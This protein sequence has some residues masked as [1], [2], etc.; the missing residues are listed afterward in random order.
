LFKPWLDEYDG[1]NVLFQSIHLH[2]KGF[3]PNTGFEE[4]NQEKYQPGGIFNYPIM[5]GAATSQ[6]W[7]KIISD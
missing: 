7:R 2:G 4:K 6:K 5:P 1:N 3:Y